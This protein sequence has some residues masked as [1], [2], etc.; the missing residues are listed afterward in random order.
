MI[1]AMLWTMAAPLLAT[2]L[3]PPPQP[4]GNRSERHLPHGVYR[5]AGED[6]WLSVVVRTDAEWRR[7]CAIHPALAPMA[8][9][10][11]RERA[12]Q[13]AAIDDAL[14][15]WLRAR[16]AKAVAAELSRAGVPAAAL[17]TSRDLVNSN[18]LRERG[19]WDTHGTGVL[20]GLPWHA[21]FGRT[22]GGAPELGADTD[23]VLRNVLDLSPDQIAALRQAGAVG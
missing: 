9:F 13:R 6:D 16:A 5:C 22:F 3:G 23:T 20:P 15:N 8:G 2:Q 10:G 11:F 17:A 12:E 1:E 4:R 19:F 14:T 7:L 21:S 18:H